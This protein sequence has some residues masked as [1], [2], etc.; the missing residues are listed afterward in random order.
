MTGTERVP[1]EMAT[2]PLKVLLPVRT[3]V[4]GPDLVRPE[5]MKAYAEVLASLAR[6]LG[7]HHDFVVLRGVIGDGFEGMPVIDA[8][9]RELELVAEGIAARVYAEKPGAWLAR[10]RKYWNAWHRTSH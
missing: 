1:P 2:G 6:V 8:R 3:R 7:D 9:L 10:M 5:M 4:P